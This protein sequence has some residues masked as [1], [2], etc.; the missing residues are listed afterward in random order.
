MTPDEAYTVVVEECG[1]PEHLRDLCNQ[2]M[3]G[4]DGSPPKGLYFE[5]RFCGSLGLGGKLWR[6]REDTY[7]VTYY[8]E[9]TTPARDE[10]VLRANNRLQGRA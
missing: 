9:D 8:P 2:W 7:K 5:F 1:A 3:E 10:M 4:E 6:T